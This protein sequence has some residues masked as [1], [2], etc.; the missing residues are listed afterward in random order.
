MVVGACQDET[1]RFGQPGGLR[2][3]SEAC[4]LPQGTDSEACP[5][6]GSVV[7]PVLEAN[8]CSQGGCHGDVTDNAPHL[9]AGDP[10]T[11][12]D[13]MA[14][15]ENYSRPYIGEGKQDTAFILCNLQ[16]KFNFIDSRVM[17]PGAKMNE[18]DLVV[19][20]NWVACGM[21]KGEAGGGGNAGGGGAGG[22][23][24]GSGGAGSASGGNS[25]MGGS[26]GVGN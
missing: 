4:P 19:V 22:A 5:D 2:V 15:Y 6:W 21:R 20:G 7:Y 16:E 12:Y 11:A 9:P 17:P 25:G 10:A 8:N 26:G 24:G 18:A 23:S 14:G 3:T 1:V 13:N